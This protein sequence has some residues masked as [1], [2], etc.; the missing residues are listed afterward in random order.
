MP[1]QEVLSLVERGQGRELALEWISKRENSSNLNLHDELRNVSCSVC[2]CVYMSE[3]VCLTSRI[4]R[5]PSALFRKS[6]KKTNL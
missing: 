4:L 5:K 2:V 6:I 1:G 3:G